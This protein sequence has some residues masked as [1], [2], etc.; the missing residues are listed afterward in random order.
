V[1]SANNTNTNNGYERCEDDRPAQ[2]TIVLRIIA[3]PAFKTFDGESD[4]QK[5]PIV[6]GVC[7]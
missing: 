1:R 7:R 4:R 2:K 5:E 6:V 3:S